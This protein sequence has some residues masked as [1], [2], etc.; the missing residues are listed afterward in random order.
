MKSVQPRNGLV[1]IRLI[2][3]KETKTASGII[4]SAQNAMITQ[5]AE[6]VAVGRGVLTESGKHGGTDDLRPGM[7][8]L[9][10]AGQRMRDGGGMTQE[11]RLAEMFGDD[12]GKYTMINQLDV[13]GIISNHAPELKMS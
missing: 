4:I 10:K 9:V 12:S 11:M 3:E 7:R 1:I 5:E 8:V 2:E 6:I 13:L